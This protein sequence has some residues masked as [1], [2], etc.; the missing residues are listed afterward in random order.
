MSSTNPFEVWLSANF[1]LAD[2]L[3]NHSVYA[4][5]HRNSYQETLTPKKLRNAE[6]LCEHALEP[7][8]QHYGPVSISYG[9][10]SPEFSRRTVTYQD[11]DKP[12]HHRWDLGAAADVI[13]HDW[14]QGPGYVPA[15]GLV[16]AH[17]PTNSSPILL[18]HDLDSTFGVPYSR[19]IT[20]S[21]SPYLC[22]AVSAD[23][24]AQGKP[25]FAFYENRYQ[26]RKG[27]KPEYLRLS[28]VKA[29]DAHRAMLLEQG[30]EFEWQGGGYPSYHGGGIRQL[31]HIRTS[32]YTMLSDWL[33]DL[34]SISNGAINM[35]RL[36]VSSPVRESFLAAGRTFDFLQ[37]RVG[38]PRLRVYRGYKAP[39]HPAHVREEAWG[40]DAVSFGIHSNVTSMEL[41]ERI[42]AAL[43]GAGATT[44]IDQHAVY[45]SVNVQDILSGQFA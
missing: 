3:G 39:G 26:G 41:Q 12:S 30:L 31:Q 35:P 29:R 16:S 2:F 9:Y 28:T 27:A 22:L 24:V 13:S 6:A 34:H 38:L 18:A 17:A 4:R 21:E 5:G 23:E 36:G 10:I 45:V 37:A 20:Y 44:H 1:C 25:R 11:P 32:Y 19:L 42:E 40:G 14:V 33:F 7:L 43:A 8:L 15:F